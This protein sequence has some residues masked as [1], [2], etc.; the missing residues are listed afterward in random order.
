[1]V[2]VRCRHGET[3]LMMAAVS[4]GSAALEVL[5]D[6]GAAV[7]TQDCEGRTAMSLARECGNAFPRAFSSLSLGAKE[8]EAE[9]EPEPE[10]QE[11]GA[12]RIPPADAAE[13]DDY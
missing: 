3:P 6:G 9:R 5:L 7:W 11:E 13:Y 10:E 8:A 12:A 2:F 1:M 4:G